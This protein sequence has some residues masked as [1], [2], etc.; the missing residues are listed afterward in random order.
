MGLPDVAEKSWILPC[1]SPTPQFAMPINPPQNEKA[2][3]GR[4][5]LGF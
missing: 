5:Q 4:Y 1:S 2:A 3:K